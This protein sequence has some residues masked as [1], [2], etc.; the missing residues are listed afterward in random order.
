MRMATSG[1]EV[2]LIGTGIDLARFRKSPPGSNF[3]TGAGI[4]WH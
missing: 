2:D 3:S 4:P 1:E